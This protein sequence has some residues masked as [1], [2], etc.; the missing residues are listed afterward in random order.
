MFAEFRFGGLKVARVQLNIT[1]LAQSLIGL[2]GGT[3]VGFHRVGQPVG[4]LLHIGIDESVTGT[5]QHN[6]HE[7]APRHSKAC[8]RRAKLIPSGS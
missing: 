5:Q 8:K 6:D 4:T 1:S 3:S 7:D 2:R